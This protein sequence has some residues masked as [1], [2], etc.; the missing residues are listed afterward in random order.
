[1]APHRRKAATAFVLFLILSPAPRPPL[2]RS[3][4]RPEMTGL[5]IPTANSCY[6]RLDERSFERTRREQLTN[7]LLTPLMSGLGVLFTLLSLDLVFKIV[8]ASCSGVVEL[9]TPCSLPA[10]PTVIV[11]EHSTILR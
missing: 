1:M 8:Y 2:S 4:E 6:E 9:L 10:T 7:M 11:P 5:R 3:S